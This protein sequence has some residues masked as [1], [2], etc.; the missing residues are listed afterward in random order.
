M[1]NLIERMAALSP[2][3]YELLEKQ[4]REKGLEIPLQISSNKEKNIN[5]KTIHESNSKHLP[6]KKMDFS[7]FFF[8]SDGSTEKTN[9]YDFLINSAKFADQNG[10]S[11]VWTPERHF[12]DFGGL[13]PN[14]SVLSAALATVTENIELRAGSV[15]LPL[16]HPIRFTEEWSVVDNL[17]HGRVS[18]AFATGWHPVDFLLAPVQDPLYYTERKAEM[19]KSIGKV[20]KLWEGEHVPFTKSQGEIYNIKTFPRPQQKQLPIWIATN[21]NPQ[22]IKQAAKIGANILTGIT[23]GI[24]RLEET[25][26]TYRKWLEE[27]GYNSD[28]KKVAV[29]LHT[30]LGHDD[31]DIKEKVKQP[32]KEYLNNF[33][34]QHENYHEDYKKL[35]TEDFEV[36]VSRAFEIYYQESA[37]LGTH[38]KCARLVE[39]LIEIGVDEIACLIDF[40]VDIDIAEEGLHMLKELKNQFNEGDKK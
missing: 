33:M 27:F 29:M 18:V 15:V 39:K 3:Q 36:L 1:N 22:T 34:K 31:F 17:S 28:S 24:E 11:A 30:C 14:P 40:G 16:H 25:I 6:M 10:F 7:L 20:L 5:Q 2:E 37:L 9:K 8:S 19:F 38:E 26:S 4:L 21:G 23:R 12:Q 32:L 35:S 13:Y